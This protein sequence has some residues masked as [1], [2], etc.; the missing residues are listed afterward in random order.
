MFW[1][2]NLRSNEKERV[3]RKDDEQHYNDARRTS[4]GKRLGTG[5][6]DQ[7]IIETQEKYGVSSNIVSPSTI[8]SRLLQNKITCSHRGMSTPMKAIKPT[9]LEISVQ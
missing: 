3:I 4:G 9:I 8:W 5:V 6:L 2:I 1:I 7:I